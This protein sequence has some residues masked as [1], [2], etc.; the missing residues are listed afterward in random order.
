LAEKRNKYDNSEAEKH[1]VE[2]RNNDKKKN[3]KGKNIFI[4]NDLKK[5]NLKRKT[6]AK[7]N[8][9]DTERGKRR[10]IKDRLQKIANKRKKVYLKRRRRFKRA[11]FLE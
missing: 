1:G 6:G 10:A 4:D 9:F 8:T 5:L 3:L 2:K 11:K 7:G